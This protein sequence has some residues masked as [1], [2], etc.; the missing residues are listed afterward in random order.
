MS[1]IKKNTQRG[2][3]EVLNDETNYVIMVDWKKNPIMKN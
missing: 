1:F 3:F 2:F